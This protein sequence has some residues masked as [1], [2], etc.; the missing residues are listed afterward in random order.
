[1]IESSKTVLFSIYEL[2]DNN[3]LFHITEVEAENFDCTI[4][5]S[6]KSMNGELSMYQDDNV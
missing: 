6:Q 4:K 3:N 1:M 2:S 5:V